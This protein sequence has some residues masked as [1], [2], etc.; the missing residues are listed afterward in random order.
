[1]ALRARRSGGGGGG[2]ESKEE[3]RRLRAKD[4][5]EGSIV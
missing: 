1:V 2:A 5:G 4:A 3:R